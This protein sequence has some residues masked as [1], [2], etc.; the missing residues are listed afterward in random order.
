MKTILNKILILLAVSLMIVSCTEDM[1]YKDARVTPVETLYEP[2][3]GLT[4]KLSSADGASSYFSWEPARTQDN[5]PATYEVVFDEVGGDF[6]EPLYVVPSD[7]N[8]SL[9]GAS[10]SHIILNLVGEFAGADIGEE[11]SVIWTVRSSRGLNTAISSEYRTL[12]FIRLFSIPSPDA[13]YI[14]GAATEGGTDLAEALPFKRIDNGV[15]EIYTKLTAGQSYKFVDQ[16][17]VSSTLRTFYFDT[18][19]LTETP[20]RES[21][22]GTGETVA[23]QTGIYR[24]KLTFTASSISFVEIQSVWWFHCETEVEQLEIPYLGKGIWKGSGTITL[25]RRGW[26]VEERYTFRVH[27]GDG[28]EVWGTLFGTDS[29]PANDAPADSEYFHIKVHPV[30]PGDAAADKWKLAQKFKDIAIANG[31][32][33]PGDTGDVGVT[34]ELFMQG[35]KPYTHSI[36]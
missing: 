21:Y 15:F 23:T 20:L 19:P 17:E 7:N 3:E 28:T 33:N 29:G 8:G 36:D 13:V 22:D 35:D 26:G 6:S 24:I 27:T 2:S 9:A 12:N 1:K 30:N 32:V 16:K 25:P 14:T 11:A 4:I 10:V 31:A 5:G 34:F 18:D